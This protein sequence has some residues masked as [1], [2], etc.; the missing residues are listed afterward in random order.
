MTRTIL[1]RGKYID[2]GQW[3]EGSLLQG[4][5]AIYSENC[6]NVLYEEC[7][8]IV[9]ASGLTEMNAYNYCDECPV[10]YD[11]IDSFDVDPA[12]LGE[13]TGL[14]DKNGKKI[15]EGDI[16]K[17]YSE[18]EPCIL[19][20]VGIVINEVLKARWSLEVIW[21]NGE[22][23]GK[24]TRIPSCIEALSG[25]NGEE[26]DPDLFEVIGNIHDN[27]IVECEF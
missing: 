11:N 19:A 7:T 25:C 23:A 13:Y 9:Q 2:D 8:V 21:V 17:C 16:V 10:L 4:T 12:T 3:V 5:K 26:V 22:E 14:T 18:Y 6:K 27:P 15:F 24:Y 1:F 20:E